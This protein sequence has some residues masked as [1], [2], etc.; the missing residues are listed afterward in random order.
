METGLATGL[1]TGRWLRM[2]LGTGLVRKLREGS[3][4][5]W[6]WGWGWVYTN[7]WSDIVQKCHILYTLSENVE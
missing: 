5:V 1:V 6:K 7:K 3:G 2:G 4:T